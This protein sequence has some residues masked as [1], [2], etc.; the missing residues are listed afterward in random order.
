[1]QETAELAEQSAEPMIHGFEGVKMAHAPVRAETESATMIKK[2]L[3]VRKIVLTPLCV[4]T[5]SAM[6]GAEPRTRRNVRRTVL[7]SPSVGCLDVLWLWER[8]STTAVIAEI[9]HL[10]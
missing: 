3:I 4:G 10:S 8:T 2:E 5:D 9:L 6:R 1:M 7:I